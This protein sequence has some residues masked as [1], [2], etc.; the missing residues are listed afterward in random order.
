MGYG[1]LLVYDS[2]GVGVVHGGLID[3]TH[4][5]AEKGGVW[6][7]TDIGRGAPLELLE[8]SHWKLCFNLQIFKVSDACQICDLIIERQTVN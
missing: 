4:Y 3:V 1:G 2:D 5:V 6:L 7:L 8:L